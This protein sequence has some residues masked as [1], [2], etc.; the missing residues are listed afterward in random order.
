MHEE[1]KLTKGIVF[2]C[3]AT[4]NIYDHYLKCN[5]LL[6]YW[7]LIHAMVENTFMNAIIFGRPVFLYIQ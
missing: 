7:L 2:K 4:V 5:T 1:E 3:Y 6:T